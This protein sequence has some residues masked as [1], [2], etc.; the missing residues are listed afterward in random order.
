MKPRRGHKKL[1]GENC[2]E[3]EVGV[4]I[5][6]RDEIKER[7]AAEGLSVNA[8]IGQAIEEKLQALSE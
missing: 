6:Q 1:Y 4:S 7:A 5:E 3:I 8:W 2:G